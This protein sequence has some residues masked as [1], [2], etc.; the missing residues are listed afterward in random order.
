MD[1]T[2]T[3]LPEEIA[4]HVFKHLLVPLD[5]SALAESVLPVATV[6]ARMFGAK[7]TLLHVIERDAPQSIHGEQHL[8]D[9][10]SATRYLGEV[11]DRLQGEEISASFHVHPNRER[12]VAASIAGH[13]HEFGN[14]LI[15]LATHGSGGLRDVVIGSIAEQVIGRAAAP[16][17][18]LRPGA[19]P[20]GQQ[21]AIR[22]IVVPLDGSPDSERAL[23]IARVVARA[24][25]AEIVLVRV[26]PTRG[27]L[28]SERSAVAVMLPS[29][30]RAIL[31]LEEAAAAE[32]LA[33]ICLRLGGPP[34]IHGRTPRGD[35]TA[36][37]LRTVEAT[38][39]DFV[40]MSTHG[41]SGL[42]AFWADSVGHRLAEKVSVPLLIDATARR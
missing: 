34:T 10:V 32:Y 16:V 20:A 37:V 8:A 12:D 23:P 9:E 14:D 39:A 29:T 3:V 33:S 42:S 36:M 28:P 21:F 30:T 38:D 24:W 13:A 41:R 35:P 31:E 40:V 22:R 2:T 17:L 7:I 26:V 5:G 11:L 1:D 25:E 4:E 6:F 15:V 19:P 18:L 27:D